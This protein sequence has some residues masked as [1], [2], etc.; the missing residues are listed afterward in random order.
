M[1]TAQRKLSLPSLAVHRST[2]SESFSAPSQHY[3]NDASP[4]STSSRQSSTVPF[5]AR[6]AAR[7]PNSRFSMSHVPRSMTTPVEDD[8]RAETAA[9]VADLK[10][11]IKKAETVSEQ[12]RK[13]LGVLQLKLDEAISEQTRLEEQTHSKEDKITVLQTEIKDLTRKVRDL[14]QVQ[15][16]ERSVMLKDKEEQ[17][18]REE[19]LHAT[20]QRL[21][22]TIAQ[23]E[24]RKHDDIEREPRFSRN[25]GQQNED[26][27]LLLSSDIERSPSRSSSRLLLQK[28]KIIESLRL[29][30]AA[31]QVKIAE[32]EN[33]KLRAVS[34]MTHASGISQPE[35]PE[36]FENPETAPRITFKANRA[37]NMH[38]RAR[39]DQVDPAAAAVIGHMYRGPTG[40]L[41]PSLNSPLSQQGSFFSTATA[42]ISSAPGT[43]TSFQSSLKSSSDRRFSGTPSL[44][45]ER[46]GDVTSTEGASPPRSLA[47]NNYPGAVTTQNKLRPLRLVQEDEAAAAARRKA[48]RG[49]WISW[50]KKEEG[51]PPTNS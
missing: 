28:D 30:L 11:Q 18:K 31:A 17:T 43:R 36:T 10:E 2:S 27:Q 25:R 3:L 9:L 16:A 21:K 13:Q 33:P 19:E 44:R 22:E 41:S 12:Y 8:A 39:S 38:R 46:T 49:S 40:P 26:G 50:F 51:Q 35:N 29:E 20:V 48:N 6:A 47:M 23:R 32:L 37:R 34:A 7:R 4:S 24:S 14:D 5:S 42:G 15:A 1:S 45:S